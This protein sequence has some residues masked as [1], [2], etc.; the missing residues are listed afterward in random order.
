MEINENDIL[1]FVARKFNEPRSR[2]R[3]NGR[4]IRNA[5]QTAASLARFD[6]RRDGLHTP[7]LTVDHFKVI[8]LVTEDFDQFMEETLG[9]DD[10]KQAFQRGDRADHWV[11]PDRLQETQQPYQHRAD[12]GPGLGV[13]RYENQQQG[14][15]FGTG[16]STPFQGFG[17]GMNQTQHHRSGSD[18]L[19]S[20]SPSTQQ[21]QRPPGPVS[22]ASYQNDPSVPQRI[23]PNNEAGVFGVSPGNRRRGRDD[24]DA[25]TQ[26]T[27]KRG[28][29][30]SYL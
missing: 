29:W 14:H 23:S 17:G 1:Q 3:W 27:P 18:G 4:Q 13:G 26:D 7:R 19:N 22:R 15:P 30:D 21:G 28:K 16:T 8:N 12:S 9:S 24:F 5:F 6:A 25:E 10:S 2:F 20:L 11:A